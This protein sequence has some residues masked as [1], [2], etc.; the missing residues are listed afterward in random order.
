M[1][2]RMTIEKTGA[3]NMLRYCCI[4]SLWLVSSLAHAQCGVTM[5]CESKPPKRCDVDICFANAVQKK[6]HE[7]ANNCIVKNKCSYA[8]ESVKQ[9]FKKIEKSNPTY[10]F[11]RNQ[12]CIADKACSSKKALDNASWLDDV[13]YDF[14]TPLVDEEGEWKAKK[15]ECAGLMVAKG[16]RCQAIMAKYHI[17]DDLQTSVNKNGCG[18]EKD[19]DQIG[20][21]LKACVDT[22]VKEDIVF[23][24]ETAGY[25][26]AAL[27]LAW[28][29]SAVRTACIADRK[30]RGLNVEGK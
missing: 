29:R 20:T 4:A 9:E 15:K 8:V 22:G 12:V 14:I 17:K 3:F 13:V 28:D 10:G 23:G 24:F 2:R 25:S 21:W 18:T 19:W 7:Q 6:Q 11:Y 27:I 1:L 26:V 30:A 16:L 5:S